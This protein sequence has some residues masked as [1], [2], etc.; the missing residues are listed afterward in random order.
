MG[1]GLGIV[2]VHLSRSSSAYGFQN[3]AHLPVV[4]RLHSGVAERIGCARASK[5]ST[6]RCHRLVEAQGD[7]VSDQ[8]VQ[9]INRLG[10]LVECSAFTVSGS[11]GHAN[12]AVASFSR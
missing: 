12:G 4:E 7:L 8:R 3:S 2:L 9:A 6:A 11:L 10:R 5:A 1:G